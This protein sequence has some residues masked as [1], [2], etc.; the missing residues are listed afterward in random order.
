MFEQRHPPPL[1]TLKTQKPE[2]GYCLS[3][4]QSVSGS[5][6]KTLVYFFSSGATCSS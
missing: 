1:A 6:V 4:I 5:I 3:D 2:T